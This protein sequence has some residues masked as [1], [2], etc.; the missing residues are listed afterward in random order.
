MRPQHGMGAQDYHQIDPT[1]EKKHS[2]M[3]ES[4]KRAIL[5]TTS[6]PQHATRWLRMLKRGSLQ[7]LHCVNSIGLISKK[8]LFELFELFLPF[9]IS[10]A[11]LSLIFHDIASLP[12]RV[13][14]AISACSSSG[15]TRNGGSVKDRK[16]GSAFSA[17]STSQNAVSA[18][19]F[20]DS[21]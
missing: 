9:Y 4:V 11:Q 12:T 16:L 19:L 18:A 7:R 1:I 2:M 8:E 5:W 3:M 20:D 14:T 6:T 13:A 17:G 10:R 15:L 21:K